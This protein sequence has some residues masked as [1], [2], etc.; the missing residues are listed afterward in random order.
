MV[1]DSADS[2]DTACVQLLASQPS[3]TLPAVPGVNSQHCAQF[4]FGF[5]VPLA[6]EIPGMAGT[7]AMSE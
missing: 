4:V 3:D 7:Y 6:V 2:S 1:C 5:M